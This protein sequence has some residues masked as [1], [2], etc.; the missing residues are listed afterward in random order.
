M[1]IGMLAFDGCVATAFGTVGLVQLGW[2][3]AALQSR[4]GTVELVQ[5]SWYTE[6]WH[7]ES[8]TVELL[9]WIGTV[10]LVQ[11]GVVL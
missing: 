1:V 9:Q 6:C 5:C 2:Y 11:R 3:S 7:S 10:G 4:F 8:G